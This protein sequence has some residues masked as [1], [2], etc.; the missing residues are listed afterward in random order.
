[1]ETQQRSGWRIA[2]VAVLVL[3]AVLLSFRNDLLELSEVESLLEQEVDDDEQG[4]VAEDHDDDDEDIQLEPL[5]VRLDDDALE[6]VG[7]KTVTLS[8]TDWATETQVHAR[9][10]DHQALV[11][12]HTTLTQQRS[13]IHVAQVAA[14]SA[15]E[16]FNRL[17]KV[18]GAVAQKN[19]SYAKADWLKKQAELQAMKTTFQSSELEL[20]QTWGKPIKQWL[21]GS[22]SPFTQIL[23]RKKALIEVALPAEL[24]VT[25]HPPMVV[26]SHLAE[27]WTAKPTE[28]VSPAFSQSPLMRSQPHY[29]LSSAKDLRP[30]MRLHAWVQERDNVKQGYF[31]PDDAVVWYAGQAWAYIEEEEGLYKRRSLADGITRTNGVFMETGFESGDELVM[32]GAQMLLSEEFRWQIHDEDDDDD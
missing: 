28:Y 7:V 30:N 5:T 2:F 17:Q 31:I 6:M 4:E 26:I 18:A 14:Q 22:D 15:K 25:E 23:A 21:E 29:F 27:R 19:I 8:V 10:V 11:Q 24:D 3:L 13:D 1:M 20:E 12:W 32:S 9:V 16:E